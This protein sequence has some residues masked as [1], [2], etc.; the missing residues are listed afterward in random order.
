MRS[1]F[2]LRFYV[3]FGIGISQSCSLIVSYEYA[4]ES[5]SLPLKDS[6]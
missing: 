2:S 1:I 4:A 3:V 6:A 5:G